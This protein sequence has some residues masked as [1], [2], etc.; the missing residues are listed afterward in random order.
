MAHERFFPIAD[1]DLIAERTDGAI[2]L[3]LHLPV[4]VDLEQI[5]VN[6]HRLTKL[7]QWAGAQTLHLATETEADRMAN[8]IVN[9]HADGSATMSGTAHVP[10]QPTVTGAY[11]DSDHPMRMAGLL[12][13]RTPVE[14]ETF[15]ETYDQMY[16][17][18]ELR[19]FVDKTAIQNRLNANDRYTRGMVDEKG[20]AKELDKAARSGFTLAAR[21][22]YLPASDEKPEAALDVFNK[23]MTAYWLTQGKWIAGTI[24]GVNT[25]HRLLQ[26][27]RVITKE[28][29]A[30]N[31]NW[32]IFTAFRYDRAIAAT[33][34]ANTTHTFRVK[35]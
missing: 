4:G 24:I 35:K 34:A 14:D 16:K 6:P 27:H 21:N 7:T 1:P 31:F 18:S 28:E 9:L 22:R 25:I 5:E 32:S 12:G 20:W 26:V 2:Q 30:S 8:F 19:L 15:K 23:G 11:D 33:V 13:A 17:A 3:G 10:K 29:P